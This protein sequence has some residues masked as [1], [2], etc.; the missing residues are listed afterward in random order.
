MQP[1][2]PAVYAR[3]PRFFRDEA[4]VEQFEFVNDGMNKIG[5]YPAS[6]EDRKEHASAYEAFLIADAAGEA[7]E[8][9]SP[10]RPVVE[11]VDAEAETDAQPELSAEEAR[12]AGFA[13]LES[14]VA[15]AEETSEPTFADALAADEAAAETDPLDHDG[16]GRKG[17][18]LPRS[19]RKGG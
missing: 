18:S 4:G 9:E 1:E 10:L 12:L 3:G 14:A 11:V 19:Q 2:R 8:P 5:P 17:G 15:P 6:D 16:D 13:Q 7:A